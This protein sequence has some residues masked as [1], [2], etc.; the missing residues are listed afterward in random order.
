MILFG[1]LYLTTYLAN[2]LLG[3]KKWMAFWCSSWCFQNVTLLFGVIAIFGQKLIG[4]WPYDLHYR[5]GDIISWYYCK[6]PFFNT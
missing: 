4:N 5:E 1:A 2:T 3:V 6:F